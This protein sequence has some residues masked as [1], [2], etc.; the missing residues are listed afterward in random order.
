MK[1]KTILI[2]CGLAVLAAGLLL[3]FSAQNKSNQPPENEMVLEIENR[4]GGEIGV[5]VLDYGNGTSGINNADG[6]YI[7]KDETLKWPLDEMV[8]AEMAD[9]LP[10]PI[11]FK[12]GL[13]T[14]TT[15]AKMDFDYSEDEIAWLDPIRAEVSG[16][17][18]LHFILSGNAQDGYQAEKVEE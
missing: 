10:A 8:L 12:F 1:K 7:R 6:S 11:D 3:W 18:Q 4:T 15:E 14:E 13:V 17:T 16:G 2:I 5:I 9:E